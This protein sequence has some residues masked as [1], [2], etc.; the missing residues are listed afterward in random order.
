MATLERF[1]GPISYKPSRASIL[2]SLGGLCALLFA[3]SLCLAQEVKPPADG[4]VFSFGVTVVSSSWLKGDIYLLEPN[5]S[6]LPDFKKLKPIGSIYTPFLYLPVRNFLE[7]FPGVTDRFE[8]FAIDYNG[9][10]WIQKSGKYRFA[11]ESDDGAKLYIDSKT[12]IDNDGVHPP[13]TKMG[14]AN[15]TEGLHSIRISYFQGPREQIA[16]ILAIA[17]PK[18]KDFYIFNME[19]YLPPADA[20]KEGG[21]VPAPE[22]DSEKP[23]P[24]R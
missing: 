1:A 15:L 9:Q 7:G 3:R 18:Q 16:L 22:V 17:E 11:L 8:W 14:A 24:F 10:F 12:I 6:S 13:L 23:H 4:R 19:K 2:L 21:R 5:T 20:L